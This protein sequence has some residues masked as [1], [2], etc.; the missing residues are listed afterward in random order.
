MEPIQVWNSG[1]NDILQNN[2]EFFLENYTKTLEDLKKI[3][4]PLI[5]YFTNRIPVEIIHALL[6]EIH[7]D[8]CL[9]LVTSNNGYWLNTRL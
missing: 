2:P 9:F 5:G 4:K 1:N 6:R 3:N 7:T 8:L